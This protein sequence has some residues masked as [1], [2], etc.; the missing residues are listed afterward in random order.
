MNFCAI[1]TSY[2]IDR[3]LGFISDYET[4]LLGDYDIGVVL[5]QVDTF[6]TDNPDLVGD[7][8]IPIVEL[9]AGDLA[10]FAFLLTKADNHKVH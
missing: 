5:T 3:F 8:M 4:S 2:A 9:F 6:L 10:C 1:T 7:E